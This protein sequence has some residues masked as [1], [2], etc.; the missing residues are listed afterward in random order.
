MSGSTVLAEVDGVKLTLAEFERRNPSGFFHARNVFYEA[1]RKVVEQ[2]IEEVILE[3]QAQKEGLTVE[4]LLKKH[5]DNAIEK[6]PSEDAL[7]VY[8]EGV[9][10]TQPYEAVRGQIVEAVRQRRLAKARTAY[11]KSLHDQAQI[12][13]RLSA[14][15][16]EVDLKN[17]AVRGPVDAP[18]L[19]VEYADYECPYCQ[20]IQP[21]LD[22]IEAEYKGKLRFAFKDVPL[23]NHAN[24]QK[25]AEAAQCA[26]VQGKYWEFHDVLFSSKQLGLPELKRHAKDLKLD[27][28]AFNACLDSGERAPLI[29][30]TAAE[31]QGFGMQ[32]TPSFFINGRFF[33]NG[34]SYEEMKR[35]IDEEL[36]ASKRT[37]SAAR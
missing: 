18:V 4:Q 26:G 29:R 20:Q 32:G 21:A 36:A 14:P 9:E 28:K 3:R 31:A 23:P 10:T 33:G 30:P 1:Q 15:R 11:L 27:E 12:A 24:A 2:A 25:A 34:S 6:D 13:V 7:R 5:L 37:T 35:I 17:A 16:A 19:I 22:R 8:Y